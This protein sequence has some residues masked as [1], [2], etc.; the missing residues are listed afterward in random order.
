M[1]LAT[2]YA[3]YGSFYPLAATFGSVIK[4][5][6]TCP[7]ICLVTWTLFEL[8][9][10]Q[11]ILASARLARDYGSDYIRNAFIENMELTP[12]ISEGTNV[13][14][15]RRRHAD[16]PFT[17]KGHSLNVSNTHANAARR[18]SAARH[19]IQ[20]SIVAEGRTPY[21]IN[22]SNSDLRK[23]S[24][25]SRR[26]RTVKDFTYYS[27]SKQ[28]VPTNLHHFSSIDD[29]DWYTPVQMN[30]FLQ[31]SSSLDSTIYSYVH[32]PVSGS[33]QTDEFTVTYSPTTGLWSFNCQDSDSYH[34]ELWDNTQ[35]ITSHFSM[36]KITPFVLLVCTLVSLALVLAY[37]SFHTVHAPLSFSFLGYKR[38]YE[39]LDFTYYVLEHRLRTQWL[40]VPFNLPSMSQPLTEVTFNCYIPTPWLLV[41]KVVHFGIGTRI[42]QYP[43]FVDCPDPAVTLAVCFFIFTISLPIVICIARLSGLQ[44]GFHFGFHI[45]CGEHRAI[46]VLT[47]GPRFGFA[48]T[49]WNILDVFTHLPRR[50][51]PAVIRVPPTKLSP[52]GTTILGMVRQDSAKNTPIYAYNIVGS[53]VVTHFDARA[54]N[55]VAD[56]NSRSEKGMNASSFSLTYA[57]DNV[58]AR[59]YW[60]TDQ[61]NVGISAVT[62]ATH[63]ARAI[64]YQL[65]PSATYYR[66]H[67][68][69]FDPVPKD[70]PLK[71]FFAGATRGLT[72]IPLST[73]G[74]TQHG[75]DTRINDV[76]PQ[77]LPKHTTRLQQSRIASF[78]RLYQQDVGGRQEL[79]SNEQVVEKQNKPSQRLT[80]AEAQLTTPG[81][82]ANAILAL[83]QKTKSFQKNEAGM[84]PGDPRN[85]TV[86]PPV[87]RLQNSRIALPLA[88][89][90]KKT[91]WYAFGKSPAQVAQAVAE[92]VSDP[93]TDCVGLGDYSRMDGTVNHLVREFD[94]AFLKVN[95][96][97]SEHAEIEEWYEYTYN[98]EVSATFG[99][100]YWQDNSQ[101][102]GDPYTS[103]LNT[104][105]NAFICYCCL[106]ASPMRNTTA[107]LTEAGAYANIGLCAGDDSLQRNIDA[108]ESAKTALTWGFSLKII[109]AERGQ[110]IDFLARQYS[111]AV[112]FGSTD[113]ICSPLRLISKFHVSAL[114]DAV[115]RDVIANMKAKSILTNDKD[116][117]IVGDWMRMI[118]C[119]TEAAACAW[120]KTARET[121]L[122]M[123]EGER[124]WSDRWAAC[125]EGSGTSYQEDIS[126]D[127]DWQI[128]ILLR[129][130]TDDS[131]GEFHQFLEDPNSTWHECPI[132][133]SASAKPAATPY[134]GNDVLV[135]PEEHKD[136]KAMPP[137]PRAPS[138][139]EDPSPM[140]EE[141]KV[142]AP[143]RTPPPN[144]HPPKEHKPRDAARTLEAPRVCKRGDRNT[145]WYKDM[146]PCTTIVTGKHAFCEVC[147]KIYMDAKARPSSE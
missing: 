41:P 138:P 66:F 122:H 84:K 20:T 16:R 29:L 18:R 131:L 83:G 77:G 123:L 45:A 144:E 108:I 111:N 143:T 23:G 68:A 64:E 142:R 2:I 129:E 63:H 59:D 56:H 61:V 100:K 98:N 36:R 112:W 74:N 48:R 13:S 34:Q 35:S 72:Y 62:H 106:L 128:A 146:Q 116:T 134:Y 15:F 97:P 71:P 3:F 73:R 4:E 110:P 118:V 140:V 5:Y 94:L 40:H 135:N 126:G 60:S 86:M 55:I 145:G 12:C 14:E 46:W 53:S 109:V 39:W 137:P 33:F 124:M 117:L 11:I 89:N 132:L 19:W 136:A 44:S 28:D 141:H 57:R 130:F 104:A 121:K 9:A 24:S 90:L 69:D 76:K 125:H 21:A 7:L 47:P 54:Y 67:V 91:K 107:R 30:E 65:E 49:I 6:C 96:P 52:A 51:Q 31:Q 95:F 120:R 75:V 81:D 99:V 103:A 70:N 88:T 85:I 114:V 92:H 133:Q 26:L 37:V 105:R 25:G 78:I 93:R 87:V 80:N 127:P 1:I 82:W 27:K 101:A 58:N 139:M 119:Q 79:W 50:L 32:T 102:S 147:N 42:L 113:N 38:C 43:S 22:C 115:P 17:L 8:Y 10:I